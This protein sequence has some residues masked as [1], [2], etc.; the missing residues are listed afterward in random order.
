MTLSLASLK[1]SG[2][3]AAM[4]VAF[5][6]AALV[7][8]PAMAASGPSFSFGIQIP[9]GDVYVGPGPRHFHQRP[10]CLGD[11]DIINEL[12]DAGWRRVQIG[13]DIGRG[14][15]IA[16]AAWGRGWYQMVVNRCTGSVN[17]VQRISR[18]NSGGMY[19]ND[20]N[21]GPGGL[22]LQFNFGN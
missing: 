17:Q 7:A 12:E 3:A 22:G 19:F 11:D 9:G 15:V 2:R 1:N 4:A 5:S 13:D 10:V 6:T 20:H 18:G 16:Y 14:R 21:H 8:M